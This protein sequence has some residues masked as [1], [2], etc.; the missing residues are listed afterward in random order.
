MRNLDLKN[1]F[2]ASVFG[3]IVVYLNILY[4]FEK[5]TP[6][7]EDIENMIVSIEK[8]SKKDIQNTE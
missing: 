4:Y 8:E 2:I 3:F 6:S 7:F 1:I 5:M